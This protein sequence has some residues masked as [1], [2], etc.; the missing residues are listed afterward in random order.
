[1]IQMPLPI[2]ILLSQ[3]RGRLERMIASGTTTFEV[4]SG[5]ALTIS[6]EI[7]LL[8]LLQKLRSEG[9]FDITSTLL[10]A[11]A[12]PQEYSGKSAVFVQEV[13]VPSINVCAEQNSRNFLRCFS[14]GRRI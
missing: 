2:M 13:V 3:T 5:Y 8:D 14:G 4:K 6:G 1:M 10:S 11:H 7:R 12:I 9:K